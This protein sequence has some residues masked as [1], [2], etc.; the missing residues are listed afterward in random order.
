LNAAPRV[1][2]TRDALVALGVLASASTAWA[3]YAQMRLDGITFALVSIALYGWALLLPLVLAAGLARR[4]WVVV[5][6]TVVT[7]ALTAL[8]IAVFDDGRATMRPRPLRG[9]AMFV[10]L[11]LA[12][13]PLMLATPFMQYADRERVP[14]RKLPMWLLTAAVAVA[15]VGSIL[16]SVVQDRAGERIVNGARA[17]QP[18]QLQPY[19]A[20]ARRKAAQSVL[21]PYLWGEEEELKWVIF[22]I[23]AHPMVENQVPLPPADAQAIESLVR[24]VAGTSISIYTGKL[25]GK[26][27]W[28]RLMGAT[29]AD[30][31]AVVAGL[32]KQHLRQ[33]NAFFGVP[34]ADWLCRPLADPATAQALVQLKTRMPENDCLEFTAKVKEQCGVAL[35]AC[36]R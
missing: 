28:D 21:G 26:L 23:A 4:K 16:Y 10:V 19:L 5:A 1:V 30:R 18:G 35:P 17:V 25:E 14:W 7:V 36:P 29:P 22:G 9:P 20:E 2:G 13:V 24:A 34:H 15:P 12:A 32:S 11:M 31:P 8:L 6:V 3:S 33:F 27:V